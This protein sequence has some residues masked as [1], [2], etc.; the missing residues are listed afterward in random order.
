MEVGSAMVATTG[1]VDTV[2]AVVTLVTLV[3]VVAVVMEAV[4]VE[5]H[6][7]LLRSLAAAHAIGLPLSR[8]S[9]QPWRQGAR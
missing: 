6:E 1:T 4:D 5:L 9:S 3:T 8:R 7:C 2:M